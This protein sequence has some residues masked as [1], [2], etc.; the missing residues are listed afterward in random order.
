MA[1]ALRRMGMLA[2]T[3]TTPASAT[4]APQTTG[5]SGSLIFLLQADSILG[6]QSTNWFPAT[7]C[8]RRRWERLVIATCRPRSSNSSL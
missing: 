4:I 1:S 3:A 6:L 5:G 8:S 2:F 7:I